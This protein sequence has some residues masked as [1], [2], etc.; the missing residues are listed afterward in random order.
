MGE[1]FDT[2]VIGM[3]PGGEVA[4]SRL[5]KAGRRV[6]VVEQE[7]IGGECAYWACIPSKTLL[8]SAEINEHARRTPGVRSAQVD[9]AEA[10][11]WRDT[12]I[13]GLDDRKQRE[14]YERRGAAVLRG[15]ARIAGSGRVVVGDR[16]LDCDHIVV[17]TGSE[18]MVPPI[19]GLEE[20]EV[21]TNREATS[22]T[23][24]PGR[25]VVIG[26]GP[27][28]CEIAQ[29]LRRFGAD[30]TVVELADALVA[31]E[32]PRVGAL[33]ARGLAE[34]GVKIHLKTE[35]KC[36][37]RDGDAHVVSLDD[38]TTVGCDVVIAA[39]GRRPRTAGIG[40]E[41]VGLDATPGH[42]IEVDRHCRAADGVWAVGD[43]TGAM[44][45]THVAKYQGRV[46]ADTIL[47]K[48]RTARY[49]GIP[50][51]VFT[52]P[53]IAAVG[54]TEEQARERGVKTVTTEIDLAETLARPWT[55]QKKPGGALGLI[56]DADRR[57]LLGAWAVAP[58]AA[59]WIHQA[60]LGVRAAIPVEVLHDQ[61]A[62]FPTYAEGFQVA[63][64]SLDF[65]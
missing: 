7:L 4:A 65:K 38:G 1:H 34:E 49:D 6:A 21:W 53:E 2:V 22:T 40:L 54:L 57:V 60:A 44:P 3:G 31:R 9:W 28:G 37:Y 25:A 62:Q 36:V 50:R 56:A 58:F 13:R 45:F 46:A 42:P 48:H 51:V 27:V 14:D 63:L 23:E 29:Y 30:V 52:D 43:V 61:I 11:Q 59:E 55:L 39:S 10:A 32:D 8:R 26:G 33:L 47:G 17:A 5:L 64:A 24:L 12:M 35:I 16:E 19:E 15:R 20:A 18:P 41:T